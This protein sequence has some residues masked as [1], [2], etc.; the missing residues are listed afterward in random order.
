MASSNYSTQSV[1]PPFPIPNRSSSRIVPHPQSE[2]SQSPTPQYNDVFGNRGSRLNRSQN[3]KE[4]S[5]RKVQSAAV[6]RPSARKTSPKKSIRRRRRSPDLTPV[7]SM[8]VES[9]APTQ[10]PVTDAPT[11]SRGDLAYEYVKA[12]EESS[13]PLGTGVSSIPRQSEETS[14]VDAIAATMVGEWMWKYIR[15]KKS[16]GVQEDFPVGEDG[17]VNIA[18]GTSRHKRW[19]WLS[20]YERTIMWDSKQPTSNSALLGKKGRKR[21][22][23]DFTFFRTLLTQSSGDSIRYGCFRSHAA[24]EEPRASFGNRQVDSH[25]HSGSSFEIHRRLGRTA[26][27][28]D[29]GLIIPST[30]WSST[31]PDSINA[32]AAFAIRTIDSTH[33]NAAY[34]YSRASSCGT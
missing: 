12:S 5:L 8:L 29:D 2:G 22:F 6:I 16:F 18:A 28:V 31:Y 13:K 21:K 25:P 19:V 24:T 27:T 34:P 33:R 30:V 15:R 4:S 11:P 32:F 20:P 3:G 26:C 7:Q 17:S 10:F 9:P 1:A 23:S 14:L